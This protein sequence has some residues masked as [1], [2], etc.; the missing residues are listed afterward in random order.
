MAGKDI[1]KISRKTY[2]DPMAWIDYNSL[3][4]LNK[5]LY[6]LLS[7]LFRVPKATRV[8]TFEQAVQRFHLNED[9]I[10]NIEIEYRTYAFCLL[11]FGIGVLAFAFYLF[12]HHGSIHG[13]M[14]AIAVAGFCFA[15]AL[16]Y[17]FWAF[18]I[19]QRKLGCTLK[20]W[21]KHRLG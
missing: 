5:S 12:L 16:K 3:K 7:D 9:E 4:N 19:Q 20:D 10:K 8:E 11:I 15:Q 14:I 21:K 2:F 6:T 13:G 1:F 17:D 18:Q